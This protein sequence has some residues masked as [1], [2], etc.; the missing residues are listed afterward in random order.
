MTPPLETQ[1]RSDL[2]GHAYRPPGAPL[3]YAE[4]VQRLCI[5]VQ[6]AV[7]EGAII[8]VVSKGDPNLLAFTARRGWHFPRTTSGEYAGHHPADGDDAVERLRSARAA[9]ATHLV[10]PQTAIWWL[11]HYIE[12]RRHLEGAATVVAR[13]DDVG[14]VYA[15]EAPVPAPSAQVAPQLGR[16]LDTVQLEQLLANILPEECTVVVAAGA[17]TSLPEVGDRVLLPWHI[18]GAGAAHATSKL[19]ELRSRGAAFLVV[20]VAVDP[21]LRRNVAVQRYL[22]QSGPQVLHQRHVCTVFDLRGA[23]R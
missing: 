9:G 5:M 4:L 12:L 14:V 21:L 18:D 13:D 23:R 2:I 20:P 1:S 10:I 22:A 6:T 3:G 16:D 8:A 19:E 11:D 15:L 17:H 7:P